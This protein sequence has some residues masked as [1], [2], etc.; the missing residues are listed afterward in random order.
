MLSV[1]FRAAWVDMFIKY[2]KIIP[3]SAAVTRLFTQGSDIMMAKR[4][5]VNS[6]N[7]GIG[8]H[9]KGTWTC[10]I[11]DLHNNNSS[12]RFRNE[13]AISSSV[14]LMSTTT[15]LWPSCVCY[16]IRKPWKSSGKA[17]SVPPPTPSLPAPLWCPTLSSR[18]Q[19]LEQPDTKTGAENQPISAQYDANY[20]LHLKHTLD[21][22]IVILNNVTCIRF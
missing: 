7:I 8:L 13:H 22:L 12:R 17:C 16:G 5:S 11:W 6:D 19:T 9:E 20:C 1:L 14:L 10:S 3:S 18:Y 21:N 15:L 2:N 4:T